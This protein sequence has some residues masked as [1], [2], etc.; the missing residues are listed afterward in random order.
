MKVLTLVVESCGATT[1]LTDKV[2]NIGRVSLSN[3]Y[4]SGDYYSYVKF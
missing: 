3:I 1:L 4:K 2:K